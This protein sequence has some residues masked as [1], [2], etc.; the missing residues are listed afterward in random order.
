MVRHPATRLRRAL[1]WLGEPW[2][3][4]PDR[5]RRGPL[6]PDAFRSPLRSTRLTAQLGIA[7]GLAFGVCFGTGLL[8]H[9]IQH[10]P[11]WFWWP[12]RPAGLYRVTQG[13][14][15]ATGLATVPLLGAKLWS[16]YPRLFAWPPLRS[17]AHAAERLSVLVLVGAALF[18]VVGG[19]FNVARWYAPMPFFFTTAHYRVAWVAAG[20]LLIHI[21]VQLPAIRHAPDGPGRRRVLLAVAAAAGLVTLSTIGQT[22]RP[23]APVSLLAPRRPGDGPQGVPVNKTAAGAGVRDAALDPGYRLTVA[24]PG[25]TVELSLADLAALPQHTTVLAVACVEGWSSTGT[26]TGV[27]LRDLVALVGADPAACIVQ[28][29][30]LQAGG[31]YRSSEVATPH[32]T[33]ERTLVALRLGGEPLALDHGYPARLIAPNRPGVLQTKWLSRITVRGA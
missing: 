28:V 22:V 23:L 32:L 8:S 13:V 15:V 33:D 18:Q 4:P 14:H 29:E 11:G 31:R 17:P 16:V 26:W 10:P 12:S 21:G 24:A 6:R 25:R 7:L 1:T 9:L 30:S 27:R 5:L 3:A 2:P 19:V 20:A